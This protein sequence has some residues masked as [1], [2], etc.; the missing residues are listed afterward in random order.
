MGYKYA[1]FSFGFGMACFWDSHKS[2]TDFVFLHM[3]ALYHIFTKDGLNRS[4]HFQ[5]LKDWV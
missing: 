2:L 5:H 4:G 3:L 1:Y